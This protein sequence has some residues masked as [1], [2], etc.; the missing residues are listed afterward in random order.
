VLRTLWFFIDVLLVVLEGA[1]EGVLSRCL[2][3]SSISCGPSLKASDY[4]ILP[5]FAEF[6]WSTPLRR[7]RFMLGISAL[8]F[9]SCLE[10]I[11]RVPLFEVGR[12][13]PFTL[14]GGDKHSIDLC[15]NPVSLVE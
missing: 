15:S 5:Y 6:Y 9:F 3:L 14:A 8:I 10:L 1:G 4:G 11:L 12:G 7:V 2:S 13:A